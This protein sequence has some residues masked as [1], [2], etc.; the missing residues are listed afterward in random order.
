MT[1]LV[2]Q[3]DFKSVGHRRFAAVDAAEKRDVGRLLILVDAYIDRRSRKRRATTRTT[4]DTYRYGIE[5]WFNHIWPDPDSESPDPHPLRVSDDDVDHYVAELQK[6]FEPATVK[7]YMAGLRTLYKA[8]TWAGA[9]STNPTDGVSVPGDPT[10]GSEKHPP[11]PADLY[12]EMVM[13]LVNEED[14]V[15]R[16]DLSILLLFGDAG[17][18]I[19]DVVNLNASDV[20]L[21]QSVATIR[22]G[23]G[24]K[25]AQQPLTQSTVQ[26]LFAY[27]GVRDA[28]AR[29]GEQAL[30]VNYGDK[31]NER[32]R[33]HRM[34][35]AGVRGV[36]ERRYELAGLPPLYRHSHALRKT[37][38]HELLPGDRRRHLPHQELR[39][40]FRC[41]NHLY[42]CAAGKGRGARRGGRDGSAEKEKARAEAG[43]G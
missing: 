25:S 18:R 11:V 33:G 12:D 4:R 1:D 16:R 6:R 9:I 27:L 30:I 3:S 43:Q 5:N 19:G 21:R 2:L 40:A 28:Y 26:A 14:A 17:F 38:G 41:Q 10:P 23:K 36:L 7:T 35:Q 34:G 42:L 22:S 31:V 24:G 39:P 8:L 15:S 13:S 37:R 20:D 29:E 32:Y